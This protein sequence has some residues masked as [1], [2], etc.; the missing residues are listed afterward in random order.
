M[1]FRYIPPLK[2]AGFHRYKILKKG[3]REWQISSRGTI[4]RLDETKV[5]RGIN[6][7]KLNQGHSV[8]LIGGQVKQKN[9]TRQEKRAGRTPKREMTIKNL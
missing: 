1:L 2:K 7:N 9:C 3:Q 5:Q 8:A 6:W 4:K